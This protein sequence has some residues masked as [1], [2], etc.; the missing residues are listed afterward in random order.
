MSRDLPLALGPA[1]SGIFAD[2]P[3]CCSSLPKGAA[4]DDCGCA[5]HIGLDR[6][7]FTD[8]GQS[9]SAGDRATAMQSMLAG[10]CQTGDISG[11][12]I[13]AV[14]VSRRRLRNL[15]GGRAYP[16]VFRY[17][18]CTRAALT[19]ISESRRREAI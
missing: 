5:E 13:Q 19:W 2:M 3:D 10:K 15:L 16:A 6:Y 8:R 7:A 14:S 4:R 11:R 12:R 1:K 18:T 17:R 9:A